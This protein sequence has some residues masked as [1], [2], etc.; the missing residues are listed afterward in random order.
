MTRKRRSLKMAPTHHD[1]RAADEALDPVSLADYDVICISSSAGK[2]SQVALGVVAAEAKR[3]GI[4]DRL[5]VVHA[6]LGRV[7][8][9]GT[10]ELAAEQAAHYGLPFRVVS[11]I[12]SLSDG[13]CKGDHPLY[14][15][16]EA[17]GDLLDQVLRRHRQ[18]MRNGKDSP[19]WP[20]MASRWCTSDFK[21]GPL[22]GAITQLVREWRARQTGPKRPCRVLDV[23]GLRAQES[24]PRAQ[25]PQLQRRTTT[26]NQH[27]DTFLPIK[28]WTEDE[29]WASIIDS[30]V[31][32]HPAY[33]AGMPRLSCAFCVFAGRDA[34]L[35]AGEMNPKLLDD[36]VAVED[37][38][39]WDFKQGLSLRSIRDAL[40]AG[41][42][43]GKAEGW[44]A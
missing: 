10:Q 30:G 37:E 14:A 16:G 6:D 43:G 35:I 32:Y 17:R 8:W 9:L 24:G 21:R 15:K 11:R 7:E 4:L 12:G 18:L 3:L 28:W 25:Q 39:G 44:A 34:L 5:T 27:V 20:S 23:Q 13:R 33:D 36:Y 41:E 19:A 26:R 38:T 1:L 42:R 29:V 31:S 2:D 22:G 40:A